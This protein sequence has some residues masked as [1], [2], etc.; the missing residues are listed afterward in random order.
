MKHSEFPH[1]FVVGETVAPDPAAFG[2]EFVEEIQ[3][4]RVRLTGFGHRT[5][6]AIRLK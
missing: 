4:R 5:G 1:G 6:N 2:A 3:Q